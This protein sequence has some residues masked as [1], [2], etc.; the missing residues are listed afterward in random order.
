MQN[1][2]PMQLHR[3]VNSLLTFSLLLIVMMLLN[4]ASSSQTAPLEKDVFALKEKISLP[5]VTG[6][7]DHIAY[8]AATHRVFIAALGNNTIEVVDIGSKQVQ[9]TITGLKEP[10]GIAY[11]PSSNKLVVANGG[12]GA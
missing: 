7:I 3:F 11:I 6:R 9:H 5:S 8:D 12:D 4:C 1:S 10:Q 2:K